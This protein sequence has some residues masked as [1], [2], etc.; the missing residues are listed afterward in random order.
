MQ[1]DQIEEILR[2]K[3]RHEFQDYCE[4]FLKFKYED[5]FRRIAPYGRDGD[6]GNDGYCC[7]TK[8][9]FAISSR[10]DTYKKI[11]D[12]FRNCMTKNL[13]IKKFTYITNRILIRKDWDIVDK[14]KIEKPNIEFKV[15][16]YKDLASDIARMS[17]TD[18]E[19]ILNRKL[20][21][22]NQKTIFFEEDMSKRESF[23][24]RQSF[25]DSLFYY[26][27]I[28]SAFILLMIISFVFHKNELL[29]AT[30]ML[31]TPFLV[32]IVMVKNKKCILKTKFP[33]RI[34][35]LILSGKLRV[36][37]EVLFVK[38][39]YF[40]IYRDS[41][42]GFTFRKRSANCIKTGCCGKVYL[43]LDKNRSIIGKCEKDQIN[44][45]YKVDNNFY[46]E[47]L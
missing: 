44:H 10:K 2:G 17:S 8:E 33:L 34:I 31:I 23:T 27:L 13:D 4:R 47:L 20:T 7:D 40:S 46:G 12:D 22:P 32:Y 28:L 15:L 41:L 19:I 36:E 39:I 6:G 26:I 43:H 38:K 16:T 29:R 42:W 3:E 30:M 25:S 14:L 24:L 18:I 5:D 45:T 21:F 9:Y 35:S 11:E 1:I 37:K